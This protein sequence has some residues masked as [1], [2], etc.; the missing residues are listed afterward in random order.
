M[1]T[2]AQP[3]TSALAAAAIAD[4]AEALLEQCRDLLQ[5]HDLTADEIAERLGKSV[6]SI[7]PRVSTLHTNGEIR[8]AIHFD[9]QLGIHVFTRRKNS[10]GMSATVWT[11]K[12][13]TV[14]QGNLL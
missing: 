2:L 8:K 11:S 4:E 12:P 3:S 9:S 7:R 6:L 1:Q 13:K 5:A 10:S 14:E